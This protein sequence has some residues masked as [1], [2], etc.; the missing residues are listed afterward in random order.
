MKG[1]YQISS[2]L[3]WLTYPNWRLSLPI[4]KLH[5]DV[6]KSFSIVGFLGS[7]QGYSL[8][9]GDRLSNKPV[10][11]KHICKL[12]TFS[13]SEKD[14]SSLKDRAVLTFVF[15]WIEIEMNSG[16][17]PVLSLGLPFQPKKKNSL[18]KSYP[19]KETCSS[20]SSVGG[21]W[22]QRN[23]LFFHWTWICP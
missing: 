2:S 21:I 23:S 14:S 15:R 7:G 12:F 1:V 13:R 11:I 3:E 9:I 10:H 20:T 16:I 4:F 6:G 8:Q 19:Q 5:T 22:Y 17:K 18:W